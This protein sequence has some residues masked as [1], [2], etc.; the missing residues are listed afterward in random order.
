M[1]VFWLDSLKDTVHCGIE[2]VEE[3]ACNHI[4][5]TVKK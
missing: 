5:Y 2:D 1:G 3:G 4:E